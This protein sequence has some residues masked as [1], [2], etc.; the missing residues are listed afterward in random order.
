MAEG[1]MSGQRIWLR[2]LA[3]INDLASARPAG[4]V[5]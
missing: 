2:V 1:D 3:A 5:H 4:A